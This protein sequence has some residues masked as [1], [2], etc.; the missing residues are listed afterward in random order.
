[1]LRCN[2]DTNHTQPPPLPVV[3]E[4]TPDPA[5]RTLSK[6]FRWPFEKRRSEVETSQAGTLCGIWELSKNQFFRFPWRLTGVHLHL[7][8]SL[9]RSLCQSHTSSPL[10]S[11]SYPPVLSLW[12]LFEVNTEFSA[13]E[14]Q[15]LLWWLCEVNMLLGLLEVTDSVSSHMTWFH[16]HCF[17]TLRVWVTKLWWATGVKV[18]L[19]TERRR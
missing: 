6:P 12:A 4:E 11:S 3:P 16:P 8:P 2:W 13:A 9:C 14:S 17:T 1:M 18:S 5:G 10:F 7:S 15:T 19:F